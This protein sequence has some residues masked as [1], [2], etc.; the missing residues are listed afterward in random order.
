MTTSPET[1]EQVAAAPADEY[2][3][4]ELAALALGISK[5]TLRRRI[6]S[7]A[8]EAKEEQRP[9]G[10]CYQIAAA[11]INELRRQ[12]HN[13]MASQVPSSSDQEGSTTVGTDH[14][15]ET[16]DVARSNG[17]ADGGENQTPA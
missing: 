13:G 2:M 16:P 6:K 9:Q 15:R 17:G 5:S 11:T 8:I 1:S 10:R 4:L 7:G 14:P 3:S 12:S